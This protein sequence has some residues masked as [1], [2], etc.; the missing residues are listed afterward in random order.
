VSSPSAP[1]RARP[2]AA[3]TVGGGKTAATPNPRWPELGRRPTHLD[4]RPPLRRLLRLGERSC[5]RENRPHLSLA[6][7]AAILPLPSSKV[8]GG[9]CHTASALH[10][11]ET[12]RGIGCRTP[13]SYCMNDLA[14]RLVDGP[15]RT[16]IV[17]RALDDDG[18]P[19]ALPEVKGWPVSRPLRCLML[20]ASRPAS[21]RRPTRAPSR[22][23]A[24]L[25]TLSS[26]VSVRAVRCAL[27]ALLPPVRSS[28]GGRVISTRASSR[29]ANCENSRESAPEPKRLETDSWGSRRRFAIPLNT[30]LADLA[31]SCI[32]SH[33]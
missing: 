16:P 24:E 26:S 33:G 18:R 15:P 5:C 31:S 10:R 23:R 2:G 4:P 27:G 9:R 19:N 6:S 20:A 32:E 22:R 3:P 1:S 30:L 17:L 12:L 13:G 28:R 7:R 29:Y 14:D 8:A 11:G 25:G 21:G